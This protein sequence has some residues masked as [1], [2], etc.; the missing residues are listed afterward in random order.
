[1]VRSR[2]IVVSLVDGLFMA[3][4]VAGLTN[5]VRNKLKFSA[6]HYDGSFI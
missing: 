2:L 1:M 3:E 5:I 4:T 6:V